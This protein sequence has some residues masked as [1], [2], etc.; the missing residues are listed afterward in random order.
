MGLVCVISSDW[1]FTRAPST[2]GL[3]L[4]EN[5]KQ[6]QF[7]IWLWVEMSLIWSQIF[8][9]MT[10]LTCQFLKSPNSSDIETLKRKRVME[11]QREED[12]DTYDELTDRDILRINSG[13]LDMFNDNHTTCFLGVYFHMYPYL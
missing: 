7:E 5:E 3:L 13:L 10:F 8:G 1:S 2:P 12:N 9:T 4:W 11:R 6:Y